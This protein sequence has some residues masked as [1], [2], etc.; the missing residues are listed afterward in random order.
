MICLPK[1]FVETK[2]PGYFWHTGQQKLYTLKVTGV[3]RPLV[4]PKISKFN[5]YQDVY[6]VSVNGKKRYL[7]MDYLRR[8]SV[9][10]NYSLFP[11]KSGS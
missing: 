10:P 11:V 1:E 3:L 5:K 9:D 4:K 7:Y 2:Y 6:Q 8:L